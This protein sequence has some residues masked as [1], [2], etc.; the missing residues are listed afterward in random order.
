MGNAGASRYQFSSRVR[1]SHPCH[2]YGQQPAKYH[3]SSAGQYSRA[4]DRTGSNPSLVLCSQY[5]P[6]L[7]ETKHELLMNWA[8]TT[9]HPQEKVKVY[10]RAISPN[11]I[12]LLSIQH[13]AHTIYTCVLQQCDR[14]DFINALHRLPSTVRLHRTMNKGLHLSYIYIHRVHSSVAHIPAFYIY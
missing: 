12:C 11:A 4:L 13:M 8:P 1:D 9:R 3:L 10:D 14:T 5:L 7:T 6:V 2:P